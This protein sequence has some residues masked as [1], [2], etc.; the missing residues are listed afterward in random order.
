MLNEGDKYCYRYRTDWKQNIDYDAN[1]CYKNATYFL[2]NYIHSD[3]DYIVDGIILPGIAIIGIIGNICG[4]LYFGRNGHQTYY[5]LMCSLATSDLVSIASFVVLYSVQIAFD[6]NTVLESSLYAKIYITTYPIL[7]LSQLTGIYLT[8]SLCLERYHAI[9][10]PLN[11]HIHRKSAY[12]YI[13]PV[14]T[15]PFLYN[16]PVFFKL[17]V[18]SEHW[19]KWKSNNTT[20]K[21][22]GNVTLYMIQPTSFYKNSLYQ[23]I[24]HTGLKIFFKCIIPYISLIFLNSMILKTLYN[25]TYTESDNVRRNGITDKEQRRRRSLKFS[26]SSDSETDCLNIHL[27]DKQQHMRKSQFDLAIVNFGIAIIFLISYS[28]IWVWAIYDF[29]QYLSPELKSQV[30][31]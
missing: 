4:I 3:I 13:I 8:I 27:S 16:L 21:F 24:Y 1:E 5:A 17:S 28:L 11:H 31:K 23:Q 22:I 26:I 2:E 19:E 7:Y 30:S 15:V 18:K 29:V 12:M 6:P 25:I 20:I 10:R 14:F 9:C